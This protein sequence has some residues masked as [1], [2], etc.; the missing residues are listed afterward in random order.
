M[1]WDKF[2]EKAVVCRPIEPLPPKRYYVG[3]LDHEKPLDVPFDQTDFLWVAAHS[4]SCS[5]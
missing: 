1:N 2:R 5:P 4:V 3:I